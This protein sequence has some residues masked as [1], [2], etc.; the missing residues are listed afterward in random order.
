MLLFPVTCKAGLGVISPSQTGKTEKLAEVMQF[1][2][3]PHHS[4]KMRSGIWLRQAASE[5]T[6]MCHL[7]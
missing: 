6:P 1:P 4:L 3:R 7:L 2:Q 5:T